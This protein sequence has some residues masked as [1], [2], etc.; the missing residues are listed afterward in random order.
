MKDWWK[1]PVLQGEDNEYGQY[2]YMIEELPNDYARWE[3]DKYVCRC[4]N[5]GKDSR[6]LFKSVSHFYTLDGYDSHNWYECWKCRLKMEVSNI[7]YK[8]KK[9]IKVLKTALFIYIACPPKWNWKKCYEWAL[10]IEH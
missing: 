1:A 10:K 6:L 2:D 7:K 4:D 8:F 9:K 5:C 3:F